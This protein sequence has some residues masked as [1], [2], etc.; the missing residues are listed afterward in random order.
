MILKEKTQVIHNICIYTVHRTCMPL[1]R[2]MT[3]NA[4]VW[5][6]CRKDKYVRPCMCIKLWLT[7]LVS[8]ELVHKRRDT[9]PWPYDVRSYIKKKWIKFKVY[10]A[11]FVAISQRTIRAYRVC[12]SELHLKSAL[13]YYDMRENQDMGQS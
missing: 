6:S 2:V 1:H 8:K 7:M 10:T 3:W 11:V 12:R 13:M 4:S 9:W 5:G